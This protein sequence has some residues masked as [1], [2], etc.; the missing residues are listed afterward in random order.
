MNHY[1]N[2]QGQEELLRQY[3]L[4]GYGG[5]YGPHHGGWHG[6]HHHFPHFH[7]FPHH[8]HHWGHHFYGGFPSGGVWGYGVGYVSGSGSWGYW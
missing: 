3:Q 1:S 5:W 2:I 4:G 7:H 8:H 6:H